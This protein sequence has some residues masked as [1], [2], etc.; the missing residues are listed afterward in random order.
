MS[1]D[2]LKASQD[3]NTQVV[4]TAGKIE[5]KGMSCKYATST[6]PTLSGLSFEIKPSE[7][8][9]VIGRTGSGKSTLIKLLWRA[10]DNYEG[11]ILIDGMSLKDV[12][13]K[14]LRS[15]VTVVTQETALIEGTLRENIDIR[16]TNASRDIEVNKIL[17][18]LGFTNKDYARNGLDM[19]I[20]ADGSNL[21][22][23]EK[24]L[25]SFARTGLNKRKILVL[26][27]ASANIDLNTEE[28]IQACID[29][30][31]KVTTMLIVA[32]RIQ[33]IMNCDRILIL[34]QGKVA[35]LDTPANLSQDKDGYFNIILSK[36]KENH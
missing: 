32:H 29:E 8:I 35:A 34:E 21:S 23:G 26:D 6:V 3:N 31:F 16:L 12:D 15:Q 28:H 33:T 14:S 24:Q 27:E 7:K 25:V 11:N 17:D 4:V 13:F 36:M 18:R 20:D 9:G 19:K 22:A 10:L 30:E 1:V 5:F 2:K